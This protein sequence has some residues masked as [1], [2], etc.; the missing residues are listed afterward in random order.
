[1]G[2]NERETAPDLLLKNSLLHWGNYLFQVANQIFSIYFPSEFG[3]NFNSFKR[4]LSSFQ[5]E[6]EFEFINHKNHT[7]LLS[8]FSEW[9]DYVA[10]IIIKIKDNFA[11]K[12]HIFLHLSRYNGTAS[13]TLEYHKYILFNHYAL[14]LL[15]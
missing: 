13:Y 9:E 8:N 11:C 7:V 14:S 15:N 12:A 10:V 1:M 4:R 5:Y 6:V 2:M 3:Q